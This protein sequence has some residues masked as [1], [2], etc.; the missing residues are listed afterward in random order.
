MAKLTAT[1]ESRVISEGFIALGHV[2][3]DEGKRGLYEIG[4]FTTEAEAREAG[5][6]EGVFGTP[7][8]V[9]SFE[10]RLY[11]GGLLVEE[12]ARLEWSLKLP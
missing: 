10:I 11:S 3:Q 9:E 6:T 1:G 4:R 7:G 8:E 5:R 12:T 2:D